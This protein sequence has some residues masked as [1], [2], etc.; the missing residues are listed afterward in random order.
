MSLS[1]IEIKI[2]EKAVGEYIERRRPPVHLRDQVDL[3]YRIDK[4]SVEI[5]EIRALWKNPEEKIEEP[6]A[7]ATYVNTQKIWK[8]FWQRADLKWHRYE[9]DPEVKTIEQF[10]SIVEK[11]EHA[12]FW[13]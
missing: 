4:Q 2:I 8:I 1:D 5:F 12:C 7:K 10:V 9:P 11:D 13:G 6:M 3:G